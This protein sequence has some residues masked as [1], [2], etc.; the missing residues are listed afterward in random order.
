MQLNYLPCFP[1]SRGNRWKKACFPE[2]INTTCCHNIELSTLLVSGL[3]PDEPF[4][5]FRWAAADGDDH[6]LI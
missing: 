2:I 1:L 4:S 5:P 3:C 6:L